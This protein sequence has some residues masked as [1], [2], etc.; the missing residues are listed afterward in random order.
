M[1]SPNYEGSYLG[2]IDLVKAT[3]FSDNAVYAQLT[4]RSRPQKVMKMAHALG[5]SSRLREFFAI[6]LGVEAR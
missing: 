4:A 2:T 3:T 6:G 1:V 5:V